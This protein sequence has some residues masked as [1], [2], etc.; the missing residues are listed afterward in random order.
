VFARFRNPAAL[1]TTKPTSVKKTTTCIANYVLLLST[2]PGR[3]VLSGFGLQHFRVQFPHV[4]LQH[5]PRLC[6][7]PLSRGVLVAAPLGRKGP[8][9]WL[10]LG[11]LSC[12]MRKGSQRPAP[13]G[14][15]FG[16]ERQLGFSCVSVVLSWGVAHNEPAA[17]TRMQAAD[18]PQT[19]L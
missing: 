15:P 16:L 18:T 5:L 6:V 8:V 13:W 1:Y 11:L 2:F 10:A 19:P 3:G 17:Y 7:S 12:R 9:V 14:L 4:S